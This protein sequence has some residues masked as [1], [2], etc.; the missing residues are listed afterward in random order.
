MAPAT[1]RSV[2]VEARMRS[3]VIAPF[4]V[5]SWFSVA[6]VAA[7]SAATATISLRPNPAARDS[8]RAAAEAG[9]NPRS[10]AR[11][12]LAGLMDGNRRFVAGE[13]THPQ[14]SVARR[15]ELA[16]GQHPQAIVLSCADSRVP[17]ELVLDQGLGELFVVRTAGEALDVA[18]VAS[19]EYAIEHLHPPLL[20]VLGHQSCGAVRSALTLTPATAGSEDLGALVSQIQRGLGRW[21]GRPP[22]ARLDGPVRANVDAML[23]ALIR[24]SAIVR[25]HV[26]HG[27][28]SA[29]PG[30]YVLDSGRVEFW[31]AAPVGEPSA[32][33][34]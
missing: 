29:V 12:A 25:T 34:R 17:P 14:Q 22:D 2:P 11:V 5:A 3:R 28:L 27:Q 21:M 23:A 16:G 10:A 33:G 8:A 30:I 18:A 26:E 19:I 9:P 15:Q 13:P 32:A 24:R 4:L 6:S 20:V 7:A 1:R 31:D